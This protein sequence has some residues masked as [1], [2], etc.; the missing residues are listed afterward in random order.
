MRKTK[1]LT[2]LMCAVFALNTAVFAEAKLPGFAVTPTEDSLKIGESAYVLV[3]LAD[4][5]GFGAMQ[6][7]LGYD[8]EKLLLEEATA[9]EII[10]DDVISSINTDI[11]GEINFSAI[12]LQDVTESGTVFVAKFKAIE[13]GTAKTDLK[14]LAYADSNGESID[15]TVTDSK[16]TVEAE[17]PPMSTGGSLNGGSGTSK[18]DK[19]D[20][21]EPKTNPNKTFTDVSQTHWAKEYIERAVELGIVSGYENGEFKPDSEMTRAEF[22]TVLWNIAEKPETSAIPNF[23]DVSESDWFYKQVAWGYGEGIISGTSETAFSPNDKLTREQAMTILY[24]YSESPEA[25]NTLDKFIDGDAV[26][27]YAKNAMN[28]AISN[29]II[30]GIN[31]T[32]LSPKTSATRAQLATIM[33]RFLDKMRATT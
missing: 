11:T 2:A 12:S 18:A 26:S 7:R 15:A 13:S 23:T 5:V 28:W 10:T 27:D 33:V 20:E 14:I 30:S 4:N 24:R 32:E 9:G 19:S 25:E 17:A 16:I 8:N 3:D 6:I 1:L 21:S 29:G 31:E 22:A